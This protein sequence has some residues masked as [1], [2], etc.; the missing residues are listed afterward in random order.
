LSLTTFGLQGI[1][2]IPNIVGPFSYTS[3]D[4]TVSQTL[5]SF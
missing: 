5:F 4:G 1:P 3:L 2:G